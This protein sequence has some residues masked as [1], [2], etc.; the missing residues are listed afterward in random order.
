MWRVLT[1]LELDLPY[2]PGTP[3]LGIHPKD[4]KSTLQRYQCIQVVASVFT[5]AKKP[6]EPVCPSADEWIK[7]MWCPIDGIHVVIKENE[8]V[9]SVGKWMQLEI[10][11]SK[12]SQTQKTNAMFSLIRIERW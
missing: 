4:S 1:K 2:D 12:I 10:I 8:I 6:N 5:T 11:L 7:K 9:T 3:L